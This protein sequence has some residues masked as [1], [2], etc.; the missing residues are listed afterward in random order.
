MKFISRAAP[1]WHGADKVT[2]LMLQVLLAL[3]PVTIGSI[4]FLGYG[5]LLNVIASIA[6]CICFEA[7]ILKLRNRPVAP[8]LLDGSA[9]VTGAL[10]ALALPPLMPWWTIA[11]ACLFAIVFAKHLYGGLGYNVFNPAMV[12]YAVVLISFPQF[13]AIWPDVATAPSLEM[14]LHFLLHGQLPAGLQLDAI[15]GATPLDG[16]KSQLGQMKTMREIAADP[17][18]GWLNSGAWRWL[19]FAALAGG[20]Y[21]L[22]K[23]IIRWHI[24]LAMLGS[25]AVLYSIFYTV[26][27]AIYTS[28]WLGLFS[29]GTMLGA[30]F[31]ATDPVS[32]AT[33][34]RGRLAYGAG[35]GILCFCIRQWG[36]YPDG[37]AFSVLIMN[38]ATP[39][40]DRF[41]L[42]R[43]YGRD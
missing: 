3:L 1:H 23:K 13:T 4:W 28:P 31:I 2:V 17:T 39:I 33:T 27:P 20:L 16:I 10:I 5:I 15:S 8:G 18:F 36:A 9:A 11:I 21:M 42:P 12:G 41:T 32:S 43:I 40:I 25:M 38:M 35:I 22:Y 26:D 14:A 19:N 34:D 30:F 7:L 37:I 6:A 29:G 24:P